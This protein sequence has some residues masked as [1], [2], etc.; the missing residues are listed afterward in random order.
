MLALGYP[1]LVMLA[2]EG[3]TAVYTVFFAWFATG[4]DERG[5]W[6]VLSI[7][8]W[9]G[10]LGGV[11]GCLAKHARVGLNVA[12]FAALVLAVAGSRRLAAFRYKVVAPRTPQNAQLPDV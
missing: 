9:L 5:A 10:V 6:L 3:Y 11:A 2:D 7:V 1:F 12:C 8:A 4:R